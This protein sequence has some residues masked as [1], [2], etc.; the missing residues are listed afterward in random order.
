MGVQFFCGVLEREMNLISCGVH[1]ADY[2]IILNGQ[3]FDEDYLEQDRRIVSMVSSI[4]GIIAAAETNPRM[5]FECNLGM[6]SLQ[7]L[8]LSI[9]REL[10]LQE[11]AIQVAHG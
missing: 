8:G 3:A 1:E 11:K 2:L 5:M 6:E 7:T 9:Y 4:R 10:Q